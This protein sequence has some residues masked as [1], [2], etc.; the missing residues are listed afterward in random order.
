MA[1]ITIK[2][3]IW[4]M[5]AA[6][7]GVMGWKPMWKLALP[8]VAAELPVVWRVGRD[9]GVHAFTE[10]RRAAGFWAGGWYFGCQ[11]VE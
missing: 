7:G 1:L 3:E 9:G 11:G 8:G 10:R 6:V 2:A 4:I 5:D